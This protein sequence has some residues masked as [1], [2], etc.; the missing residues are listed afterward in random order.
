MF[1]R[2][3]D[4]NVISFKILTAMPGFWV[5]CAPFDAI[6]H[7]FVIASQFNLIVWIAIRIGIFW[8]DFVP[9]SVWVDCTL[10]AV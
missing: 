3:F 10:I 9:G 8:A 5:D 2:K 7:G 4:C 6:L 1:N